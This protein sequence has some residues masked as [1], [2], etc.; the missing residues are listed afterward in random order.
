MMIIIII[1]IIVIE[2]GYIWHLKWHLKTSAPGRMSLI[3][4][5]AVILGEGI[6]DFKTRLT[7][8]FSSGRQPI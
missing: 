6:S 4:L 8:L 7:G 2:G 5:P 1:I 3:A